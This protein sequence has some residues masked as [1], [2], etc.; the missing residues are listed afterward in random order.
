[1]LD[2]QRISL[3]YVT[4][5]KGGDQIIETLQS[6]VE[7]DQKGEGIGDLPFMTAL[8]SG[9]VTSLKFRGSCSVRKLMSIPGN[10]S[11]A[12]RKSEEHR[13]DLRHQPWRGRRQVQCDVL[14]WSAGRH[15]RIHPGLEPHWTDPCR[16]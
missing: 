1:M 15:R 14:R 4:N 2:L 5:K 9:G 10:L 11:A 16:L 3:T 13:R 8:I 7:R 6:Q 12:R